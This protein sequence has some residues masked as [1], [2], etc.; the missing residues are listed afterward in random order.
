M[1]VSCER[2]DLRPMPDGVMIYDDDAVRLDPVPV[3]AIPRA[4]VI[5]EFYDA[6][7]DGKPP[8]HDGAGR[9]RRWKSVSRSCDSSRGAGRDHAAPSGR[10]A[11]ERRR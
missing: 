9:S 10:I 11:A 4:E 1:I 7:V 2:A 6:V 8:L 3:P 5:D